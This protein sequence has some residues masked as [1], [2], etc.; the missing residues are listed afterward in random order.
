MVTKEYYGD[1]I[2]EIM[3]NICG[4]DIERYQKMRN[5]MLRIVALPEIKNASEEYAL[6]KREKKYPLA[7]DYA[8]WILNV[9][10]YNEEL[11]ETENEIFGKEIINEDVFHAFYQAFVKDY[12]NTTDDV[13]QLFLN[14]NA[15]TLSLV[16]N[17]LLY[18][19]IYS[20][21]EECLQ[22]LLDNATTKGIPSSLVNECLPF[23][24]FAIDNSFVVGNVKISQIFISK[25]K[26]GKDNEELLQLYFLFEEPEYDYFYV[27]MP[28][29]EK[30]VSVDMLEFDEHH[31]H[32]APLVEKALSLLLYICSSNKEV[33]PIVEKNGLERNRE[34]YRQQVGVKK[35][36]LG[37]IIGSTIKCNRKRYVYT[38]N[39]NIEQKQGAPKRPHVRSAHYQHYRIGKGRE[40][41]IIK[42]IPPLFIKGGNELPTLHKVKK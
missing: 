25:I 41:S 22:F 21:D 39:G 30:E 15:I 5:E 23:N 4:E 36:E 6:L 24:T 11:V 40:Q 2:G 34:K 33:R 35:Q 12:L 29:N 19:Q 13:A 14:T 3:K 8:Q 26:R 42:F 18:K 37:Y 7:Y 17:W 38:E 20:F 27:F 9:M 32:L 28:L 10:P 1:Q 16:R 31:K